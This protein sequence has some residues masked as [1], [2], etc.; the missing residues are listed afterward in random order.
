MKSG[1]HQVEIEELHRE[2]T[3]FTVGP[4]GFYDN[5]YV[6]MPF[7]LSNSP[8]TYQSL[9]EECLGDYNMN[10]CVIYRDDSI[11]FSETPEKNR[12]DFNKITRMW[13]QTISRK[14][15]FSSEKSYLF[16]TCRQGRWSRN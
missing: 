15:L 4:S 2:R 5:G 8:T 6:K 14:M 11:I 3:A 10:I 12:F 13:H 7:R 16:R 9:M 1:Y